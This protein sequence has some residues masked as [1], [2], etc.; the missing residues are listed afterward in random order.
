MKSRNLSVPEGLESTSMADGQDIFNK[1]ALLDRVGGRADLLPRLLSMFLPTVDDI[2]VRLDG[3][4]AGK[5]SVEAR[6]LS[7]TLKGVAANIGAER[8]CAVSVKLEA[9]ARKEE[10]TKFA[11]EMQ[12]LRAEYELFKSVVQL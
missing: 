1:S 8:M 3:V 4:V 6:K 12:Y 7:H 5:D 2:L 10:L 9:F 11:E